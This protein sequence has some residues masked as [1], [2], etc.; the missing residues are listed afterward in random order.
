MDL[1][2]GSGISF[3]F[4]DDNVDPSTKGNKKGWGLQVARAIWY[5]RA[6]NN[7]NLFYNVRR[8]YFEKIEYAFAL[9]N[10]DAFKPVLGI[11]PREANKTF[12]PNIDWSIKNYA[13][14]RVNIAT[15][16]IINRRYDPQ[17]NP[18][19]PFA[20][21]RKKDYRSK[22]KAYMQQQEFL[23]EAKKLI[24]SEIA[25]AP[26]DIDPDLMPQNDTELD[27]HMKINYKDRGAAWLE[28]RCNYFFDRNRYDDIKSEGA[29]YE[30]ALGIRVEHVGSDE[31]GR[32]Q[33]RS[34]NPAQY[35]GPHLP[36]QYPTNLRYGADVDFYEVS[37][38]MKLWTGEFSKQEEAHIINTYAT[39]EHLY[40]DNFGRN[41]S[42]TSTRKLQIMRFEY[43]TVD[44][45][46]YVESEDEYG[47]LRFVERDY[48]FYNTPAQLDKFK[49]KYAGKSKI[50]RVPM[51][52]VYA[53][54]WIVDSDYIF[55]YGRKA[56]QEGEWGALGQGRI[57]YKVVAPNLKNGRVV[58]A[59]DQMIPILNELQRYHLK[60][61]HI[62]AASVPKGIAIDLEALRR[63]DLKGPDGKPMT[64]L[65][66][67][68][69]YQQAGIFVFNPGDGAIYG[70]GASQKP[71]YE[72]ENGVAGDIVYYADLTQQALLQL[73]E[74]IGLNE[75]SSASP[76]PERKGA[77]VAQMQVQSTEN[78]LD[79]LYKGDEHIFK[80]VCKSVG[81]KAIQ[82][83]LMNPEYY[84]EAFGQSSADFIREYR[85][86]QT[87]FGLML[88]IAPSAEEWR[89]FYLEA[90]DAQKSG[91]I[92]QS[93]LTLLR[94]VPTL[95]EAES[96]LRLFEERARRQAAEAKS[97]DIK[98]NA[99]Q[100]AESAKLTHQFDME[101]QQSKGQIEMVKSQTELRKI[102]VQGQMQ[103]QQMYVQAFLDG[104]LNEESIRI[105]GDEDAQ[106]AIIKGQIQ[107]DIERIKAQNQKSNN[108]QLTK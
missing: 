8:E 102:A 34:I 90:K 39:T 20:L 61:Q 4:P 31:Y 38:A 106:L 36:S 33:I 58:S 1:G 6:F 44:E 14:K 96:L 37:D 84:K 75:V 54:Y 71:I 29:F 80:E 51:D 46:V 19:D 56:W 62:F 68:A 30:F 27:I 97:A 43:R 88:E 105:K 87:D 77:R 83:E 99:Q 95:R 72:I 82:S 55:G 52:T 3:P 101:L 89:E 64:D 76:V 11:N 107:K 22:L 13:T 103:L 49:K 91:L 65:E 12:L 69:F 108:K 35:V 2:N 67:I 10:P 9:N 18:G 24:G 32:P 53:G 57:G 28:K 79:F 104:K 63:A 23:Q 40:Y 42:S 47:N 45:K 81:I 5:N 92:T 25:V 17:F 66:K 59:I 50:N 98:E 74:V 26:D 60:I 70:R 15:S 93:Q 21:D 48:K 16:K 7:P 86:D 85:L 73:D 41:N 100:Q 78:A 94:R